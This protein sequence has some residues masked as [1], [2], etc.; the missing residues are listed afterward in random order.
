MSRA[1]KVLEAGD[2]APDFTLPA[3]SGK[4]VKL[5]SME[6]RQ[7]VLYF[8]PK[9]DTSG[10]TTE[11]CGFR[12]S[13]PKFDKLDAVVL[14]VSKDS[15]DSH[16]RFI[17]RYSLNFILLSDEDLKVHRL[18]DTWK[19]KKLYGKKYMG[20]ERSTFVI[21]VDGKIKKIFRKVKP[22]GHEVEVLEALSS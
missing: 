17:N 15:L 1:A 16:A 11:A 19:Q 21:G 4:S 9:D 7:V 20:T 13:M 8:Y 22:K 18:Y 5:S 2:R 12:D 10:C 3:S 6:G 14:G